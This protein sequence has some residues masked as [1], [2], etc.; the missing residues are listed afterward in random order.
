MK[1]KIEMG[2]NVRVYS[3]QSGGLDA[4]RGCSLLMRVAVVALLIL[5][6]SMSRVSPR[7]ILVCTKVVVDCRFYV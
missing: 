5:D 4:R 1:G 2:R 7:I 6:V 3:T